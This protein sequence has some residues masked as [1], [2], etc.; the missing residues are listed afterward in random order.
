M[1]E[2]MMASAGEVGFDVPWEGQLMA[3][4]ESFAERL[5]FLGGANPHPTPPLNL[6]MAYLVGELRDQGFSVS[7]I[8]SA[9]AYGSTKL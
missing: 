1:M 2:E 9:L 5:A 7:D 3:A 6:A 4:V 8:R